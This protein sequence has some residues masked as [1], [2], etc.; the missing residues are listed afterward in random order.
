MFV[1]MGITFM[2]LVWEALEILEI[3]QDPGMN[4]STVKVVTHFDGPYKSKRFLFVNAL[5][6]LRNNIVFQVGDQTPLAGW[7]ELGILGQRDPPH[8]TCT[9]AV[10]YRDLLAHLK[11][12]CILDRYINYWLI[13]ELIDR[14]IDR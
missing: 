1:E 11:L 10:N 4:L 3:L 6:F 9:Q 13:K 12:R 14:F 2:D 7:P 5:K 8:R